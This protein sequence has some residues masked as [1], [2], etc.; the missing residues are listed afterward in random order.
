MKATILSLN[1]TSSKWTAESMRKY[2]SEVDEINIKEI[3]INFSGKNS[4]V[5]YQG[6]PI[7]KYDCILAKGSFRYAPLLRS[8]TSLLKG[9]AYMPL[10][11][12]SFTIGHD[13]LL[14][15]LKLQQQNIPMPRTYLSATTKSAKKILERVNYPII[16]K[17][18]HGTQGK[19]VM[20]ADSYA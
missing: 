11:A 3:E 12:S 9:Q 1:S 16:M 8:L 13:K 17:F 10:N 14:T 2:F 4:E 19:G 5:L 7:N 6:Q 18:P 15:Q 20:F